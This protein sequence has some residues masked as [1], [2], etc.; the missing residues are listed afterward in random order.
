[1]SD[2]LIRLNLKILNGFNFE[3]TIHLTLSICFPVNFDGFW[4]WIIR[5]RR[6]NRLK[7]ENGRIDASSVWT[8][9]ASSSIKMAIAFTFLAFKIVNL[10]SS[11]PRFDTRKLLHFFGT[12]WRQAK[13]YHRCKVVLYDNN[14]KI[15]YLVLL[16]VLSQYK[17]FFAKNL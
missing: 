4:R 15:S 1:M 3:W 17:S 11:P 2:R 9:N 14:N 8:D 12:N 7:C 5:L 16:T 6:I 10:L 13:T